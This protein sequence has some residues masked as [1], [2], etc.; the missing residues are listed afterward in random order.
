NLDIINVK[1]HGIKGDGQTND[2]PAVQAL[3]DHVSSRG[4]GVIYF[5]SGNYLFKNGVT[6]SGSN[7]QLDFAKNAII[8]F[9]FEGQTESEAAITFSGSE[10]TPVKVTKTIEKGSTEIEVESIPPGLKVG[11]WVK[12]QS[13]ELFHDSRP[14]YYKNE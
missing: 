5:P 4:G 1:D 8:L 7:I 6:V 13:D 3:I 14:Y 2:A 10:G 12:I 9:A 11:D